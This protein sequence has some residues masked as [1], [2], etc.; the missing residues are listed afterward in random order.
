MATGAVHVDHEVVDGDAWPRLLGLLGLFVLALFA[1]FL[2]AL[3]LTATATTAPGATA[4]PA[5]P[6]LCVTTFRSTFGARPPCPAATSPATFG[7]VGPGLLRILLPLTLLRLTLLA[8]L[9]LALLALTL[10]ALLRLTLLAL[11]LR[12]LLP[13]LAWLRILRCL[14]RRRGSARLHRWGGGGGGS[15]LLLSTSGTCHGQ[16]EQAGDEDRKTH[17]HLSGSR[18]VDGGGYGSRP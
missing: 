6:A 15:A 11:A 9:P 1:T 8:L 4:P 5:T 12:I 17:E 2:F 13:G 14:C 10:L 16:Q 3:A 7:W 18:Q